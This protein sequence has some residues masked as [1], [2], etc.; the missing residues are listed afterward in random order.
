MNHQLKLYFSMNLQFNLLSKWL[1]KKMFLCFQTSF[2]GNQTFIEFR[3]VS[4]F[5]SNFN[6][7][8]IVGF[9]NNNKK[10]EEQNHNI[11][12]LLNF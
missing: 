4:F 1:M 3:S 5:F 11:L 9:L 7:I 12:S 8:I 6:K 2:Y 10:E